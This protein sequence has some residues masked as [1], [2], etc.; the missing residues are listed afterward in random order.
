MIRDNKAC[1]K[2]ATALG[3]GAEPATAELQRPHRL[4]ATRK[5]YIVPGVDAVSLGGV[6]EDIRSK[7][8]SSEDSV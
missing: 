5:C 7:R 2:F 1:G 3:H 6:S 8:T 4:P